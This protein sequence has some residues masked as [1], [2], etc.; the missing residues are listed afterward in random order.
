MLQYKIIEVFTSE[1]VR[2]KG[3]SLGDAIVAYIRDLKIAARCMVMRA[4]DGCYES[5]EIATGRLEILS[6]NMPLKIVIVLP[7]SEFERVLPQVEA[8]VTDGIVA[9]QNIEVVAHKTRGR[10]LPRHTR[11]KDIMTPNPKKVYASTPLHEVVR[12]L[13]SSIFTGAPV[14][15]ARDR[16]IGIL[17]QTDLIRRA[18]LP[19]RLGLLAECDSTRMSSL[20]E[21]LAHKKAQDAMTQP[22][23]CIGEDKEAVEAVRLMMEKQLK[24]LPV[25]DADGK[26][27]GMLSRLDLFRAVMK[28]SPDWKSFTEKRVCVDNLRF[29]SD[30]MRRD[31]HTVSPETPVEEVIGIIDSNDIQRVAVVDREGHFLGLISDRNLLAVFSETHE[32]IWDYFVSRIPLTEKGRRHRELREIL[33]ARTASEVMNSTITTVR[34]ETALDEAIRLMAEKGFKRLPVLDSQGKFKGMI[35]RDALLRTGFAECAE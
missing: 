24:R 7:A 19:L 22:V 27:V 31:T 32:G 14:V 20:L 5:G 15:D 35:S 6:Y 9:V 3:K 8:M 18:G 21:P 23:V 17:T 33:R 29:V 16:P 12:L 4:M 30:I 2:W 25:L 28:E 10:L 34:E 1:E 11:V 13:L 26:L